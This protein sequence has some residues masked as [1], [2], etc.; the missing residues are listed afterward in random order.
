MPQ[1]MFRLSQPFVTIADYRK[2]TSVNEHSL[3]FNVSQTVCH[4][5]KISKYLTSAIAACAISKKSA[6]F[7]LDFVVCNSPR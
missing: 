7:H 6:D 3:I 4:N 2:L 5:R 1:T